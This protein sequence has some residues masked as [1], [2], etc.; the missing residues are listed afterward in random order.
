MRPLRKNGM[1]ET[2][3]NS[4]KKI[5]IAIPASHAWLWPQTCISSLLRYPP[6]AEGF[7]V[8]IVVV[9]NSWNWSPSIRGIT[10]TRLGDGVTIHNNTKL[11]KFHASAL[12]DVIE[13]FE[14][15]YLMAL[16]TDVVALHKDWLQWFVTMIE[17]GGRFAVGHWH[18]ESFV[19]PSCTIYRGDVLREMNAWCKANTSEEQRWGDNF[20]K[21]MK[22]NPGDLGWVNG[23]FADKRGWPEGHRNALEPSGKSKGFGW[24]EPGQMLFHWATDRGYPYMVC[25][26]SHTEVSGAPAQTIYGQNQPDL[27]T[28]QLE[29]HQLWERGYTAHLWGGTR[30][31]DI[32]KHS[33]SD[34][35]VL[36]QTPIWLRREARFWLE[37]VDAD[38]REKTIELIKTHGW[39]TQSLGGPGG[40]ERDA[41]AARYV[42]SIYREAGIPI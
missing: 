5:C 28:D 21:S 10:E 22:L 39:H 35:F 23:P 8:Q 36:K 32:I 29:L 31:L 2:T 1:G 18:H 26:T 25:N 41:E 4:M 19:N 14:F 13:H 15:D 27:A 34:Q 11:N 20:E 16:E 40:V 6:K 33:V 30:A 37:A 7:E 42:N 12:D 24:Y 38:V 9:D 3:S 17:D